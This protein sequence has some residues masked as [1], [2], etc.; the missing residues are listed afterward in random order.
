MNTV[1]GIFIKNLWEEQT[2]QLER[3]SL[4]K[5]MFH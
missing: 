5:Y 1:S 2:A 4:F 3:A